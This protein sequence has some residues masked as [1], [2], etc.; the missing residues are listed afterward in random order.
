MTVTPPVRRG[1]GRAGSVARRGPPLVRL[2]GEEAQLRALSGPVADR[3]VQALAVA[4]STTE[5]CA[6]Y[7]QV[8]SGPG[9]PAQ[10]VIVAGAFLVFPD[11][12]GA[13]A[14]QELFAG[15]RVRSAPRTQPA[16]CVCGRSPRRRPDRR[17][18]L[19]RVGLRVPWAFLARPQVPGPRRHFRRSGR[20]DR[21]NRSDRVGRGRA[22]TRENPPCLRMRGG[23][24]VDARSSTVD[25]LVPRRTP[26]QEARAARRVLPRPW[27]PFH[28]ALG[29]N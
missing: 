21:S 10:V 3:R 29:L 22:Q 8:V 16:R 20:A 19:T 24:A 18:R 7:I 9:V 23:M 13:V 26:W 4:S 14:G 1:C 15:R 6:P 2:A 27:C 28:P 25:L 11:L 5:P 17:P 12:S